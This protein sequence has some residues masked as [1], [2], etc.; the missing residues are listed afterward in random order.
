MTRKE[1]KT[2][3]AVWGGA[4]AV[5]TVSFALILWMAAWLPHFLLAWWMQL[6]P[7]GRAVAKAGYPAGLSF[8]CVMMAAAGRRKRG[9]RW[10]GGRG[11]RA[12][13]L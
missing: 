9:Q 3:L 4:V 10:Q 6:S 13:S 2:R 1:W 5:T 8:F 11:R 7:W 12:Q